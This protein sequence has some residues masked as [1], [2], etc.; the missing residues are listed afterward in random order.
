MKKWIENIQNSDEATKKKWLMGLSV[1]SMT[2][3]IGLW[4]IYLNYSMDISKI[5]LKN[6]FYKMM[7]ERIITIE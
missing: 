7:G 6:L 2:I 4:L 3:I 1:I 5:G